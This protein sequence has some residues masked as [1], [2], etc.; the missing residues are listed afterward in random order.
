MNDG[1]NVNINTF[2]AVRQGKWREKGK[3]RTKPNS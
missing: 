3:I 1:I 2:H